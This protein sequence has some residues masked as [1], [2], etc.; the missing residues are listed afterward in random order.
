M[1]LNPNPTTLEIVDNLLQLCELYETAETPEER[2]A[3]EDEISRVYTGEFR[4]K[5]DAT[6]WVEQLTDAEMEARA[7]QIEQLNGRIDR[8]RARK[9]YLRAM[10]Q[11]A[12][13][14][15]D[16]SKVKDAMHTASIRKGTERAVVDDFAA[17]PL[18][19]CRISQPMI[20][21]DLIAIKQDIQ[22]GAEV[23]GARLERG[24]PSLQIR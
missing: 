19:Y 15:I 20:K 13:A 18:E 8:L 22:R 7:K 12:M 9:E 11:N 16:V 3:A 2:A 17:I 6:A 24:A 10:V 4:D 1:Q 23:P 5:I 21:P 14:R